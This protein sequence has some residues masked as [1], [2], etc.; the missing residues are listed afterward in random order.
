MLRLIIKL[1]IIIFLIYLLHTNPIPIPCFCDSGS[2]FTKC[3]EGSQIDK[4]TCNEITKIVE[5]IDESFKS[6]SN[7]IVSV[8]TTLSKD[9]PKIPTN[10]PK[11]A[12]II[13]EKYTNYT[14]NN[15]PEIPE[16]N[17]NCPV[18]VPMSKITNESNKI[19]TNVN[20]KINDL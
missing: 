6:I 10:I 5:S 14:I 15:I 9:I 3:I 12:D 8:A 11:V 7:N 2:F 19:L 18:D 4:K 17:L 1:G 20:N 16:I 13:S